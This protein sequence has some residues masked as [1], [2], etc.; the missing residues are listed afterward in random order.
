M[1]ICVA[2]FQKSHNINLSCS[3]LILVFTQKLKSKIYT[4]ILDV[5][6]SVNTGDSLISYLLIAKLLFPNYLKI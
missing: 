2:K 3:H 1:Y 5:S 4:L 6:K